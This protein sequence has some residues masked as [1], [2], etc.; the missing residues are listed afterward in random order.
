VSAP[1][2]LVSIVVPTYE[3]PAALARCL[4]S[5]ASTVLAPHEVICVSVAG[6]E[7]TAD[8]IDGRPVRHLVQ[9][10]RGGF[11][12]AANMGLR[13]AEGTFVT[14]INDDCVLMP[15]T[16]E[17]AVRFLEAPAHEAVAL[18]AFFHDSPVRRNVF[19]QIE[20]E[21]TWY[22]VC[23]VRGLC[24]ANFGLAR[25]GLYEQLGYY[26]DRYHM[27]GAD[28]DFS[29]KVWHEAKREVRPCPGALVHHEEL[30]DDRGRTERG[31]QADDNRKLFEKWG[32][33]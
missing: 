22:Y 18:C 30:D 10:R 3:R 26:D 29:L 33:T 32:L 23:H 14:Q 4:S 8:V 20:V 2:P 6:D 28:P 12:E 7:A 5:I 25:R 9:E 17:N 21:G 1:P 11:V 16:I 27:Y 31:R 13:A 15:H 24:Y 19:A